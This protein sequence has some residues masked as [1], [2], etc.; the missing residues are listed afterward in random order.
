[1]RA[2]AVALTVAL[3]VGTACSSGGGTVKLD[4]SPRY[5]DDEGVVTSI[6]FDRVTLDGAR[7]YGVSKNLRSF[8][9]Y[10][11]SLEPMLNRER[12]YVQIGLSGKTMVWMAGIAAVIPARPPRVYYTGTLVRV[13]KERR[14]IFQDGT[15]LRLAAGVQ[16]PVRRGY[17]QAE[18]DAAAHRVRKLS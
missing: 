13:D 2:T 7:T 1:V 12:Q 11:R 14:V 16:P 10:D 17:V 3:A 4:G 15:V 8:S 6:D 9:T 18:I 5:P